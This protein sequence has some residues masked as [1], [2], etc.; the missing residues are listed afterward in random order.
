MPSCILT[1]NQAHR[2][3]A[4]EIHYNIK[5]QLHKAD[6]SLREEEL[7]FELEAFKRREN[8][9]RLSASR[10]SALAGFHP[11]AQLPTLL[12][13]LV[14]QGR[15]GRILLLQDTKALG[16]SIQTEEDILLELAKK[17]GDETLRALQSALQVKEGH[18]V[19]ENTQAAASL[20]RKVLEEATKSKKLKKEELNQLNEGTRNW[21]DTGFGTHHEEDALDLYEKQIGWEVRERNASIISWPFE[22]LELVDQLSLVDGQPTVIAIG[23]A[24]NRMNRPSLASK[25][26][27]LKDEEDCTENFRTISERPFFTICGSVDGIRDELWCPPNQGDAHDSVNEDWQLRP[28]IVECKHRMH[29]VYSTPPLYDQ[30]Q[31]TAY[32]LMYD[33]TEADIIQVTRTIQEQPRPERRGEKQQSVKNSG[34]NGNDSAECS[35]VQASR[36]AAAS[37]PIIQLEGNLP[38]VSSS[39]VGPNSNETPDMAA[40]KRVLPPTKDSPKS[41]VNIVVSRISLDD[42]I[43]QHRSNWESVVLPRLRSFVDAVF[44]IRRDDGKRQSLLLCESGHDH[45]SLLDAWDILHNE[46]PWLMDCD[47]AYHRELHAIS[48]SINEM[49]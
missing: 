29:R 5:Q 21:V 30:I 36:A 39:S 14:Y 32:C 35:D 6:M 1:G 37:L 47:T 42:P 45:N 33:S 4:S 16:L 24:E 48:K 9:L 34:S 27:E 7:D 46:C 15:T 12:R 25:R 2:K 31:A 18:Q 28:I 3:K 38:A 23:K 44:A 8:S 11:F 49:G 10:I 20:K 40:Q 19:L 13:E 22:K 17:A 26:I 43:M 41:V